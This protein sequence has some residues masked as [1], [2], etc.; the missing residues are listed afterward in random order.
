M[1]FVQQDKFCNIDALFFIASDRGSGPGGGGVLVII[2]IELGES[3][4]I[5]GM[6]CMEKVTLLHWGFNK[7]GHCFQTFC[8]KMV[9]DS[10]ASNNIYLSDNHVF[11]ASLYIKIPLL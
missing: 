8:C 1:G 3:T 6:K 4:A 11:I 10:V 5:P 7:H 2:Q 9:L